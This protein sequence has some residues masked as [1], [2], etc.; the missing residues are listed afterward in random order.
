MKYT[1]ILK[2]VNGVTFVV[3]TAEL[4]TQLVA[5]DFRLL[6]M[7]LKTILRLRTEYLKRGGQE[8][9]TE[10][11]VAAIFSPGATEVKT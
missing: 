5:D 2:D 8:P 9:I 6:G 4:Y 7:E 1:T 11:S 10:A 3:D